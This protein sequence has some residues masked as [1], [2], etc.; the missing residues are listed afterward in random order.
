MFQ[1]GQQDHEPGQE[2]HRHDGDENRR[3]SRDGADSAGD[4]IQD[5]ACQSEG[6]VGLTGDGCP[7]TVEG[8]AMVSGTPSLCA[9][10]WTTA[11]P[12]TFDAS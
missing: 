3:A 7:M 4:E 10:A 11:S 12:S 8:L 1:G 2:V 5:G 9:A 6:L